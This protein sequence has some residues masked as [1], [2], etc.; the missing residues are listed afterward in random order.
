MRGGATDATQQLFST[1]KS[2]LTTNPVT[3][4]YRLVDIWTLATPLFARQ[5]LCQAVAVA[6]GFTTSQEIS[7]YCSGN[8]LLQGGSISASLP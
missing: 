2:T 5:Q 3:I 1:W 4:R 7:A 8:P 6:S